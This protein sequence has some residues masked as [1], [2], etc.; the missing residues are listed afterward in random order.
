MSSSAALQPNAEGR[1]DAAE[2]REDEGAAS[3]W[4]WKDL[5]E[6]MIEPDDVDEIAF[7]NSDGGKQIVMDKIEPVN[8]Q[9]FIKQLCL[10]IEQQMYV[11][12]YKDCA[13]QIRINI[14][15]KPTRILTTGAMPDEFCL[16]FAGKVSP[17][18][19]KTGFLLG[20]VVLHGGLKVP[21]YIEGKDLQSISGE[22]YFIP[23]WLVK[24]ADKDGMASMRFSSRTMELTVGA[25]VMAFAKYHDSGNADGHKV[26]LAV[27]VLE[28]DK[29]NTCAAFELSRPKFPT[30]PGKKKG[31]GKGGAPSV[32]DDVMQ[33]LGPAAALRTLAQGGPSAGKGL[34]A[35][36]SANKK[37]GHLLR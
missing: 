12:S 8:Y 9:M 14:A 25:E 34:A 6:F 21:L 29:K 3:S 33:L 27:P 1:A 20:T 26:S 15:S 31:S 4:T 32:P 19:A 17:T 37:V 35:A 22:T 23:A 18:P 7:A 10:S 16:Y 36:K 11:L 28:P 30:A 24:Q 13:A 2:G 5:I